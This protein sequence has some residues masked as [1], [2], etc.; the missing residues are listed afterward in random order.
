MFGTTWK[1]SLPFQAFL[2]WRLGNVDFGPRGSQR[3]LVGP[4]RSDFPTAPVGPTGSYQELDEFGLRTYEEL[5]FS[6]V[7]SSWV[8]LIRAGCV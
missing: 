8:E 5:D 3:V 6:R 7:G 1:S 2:G 4:S